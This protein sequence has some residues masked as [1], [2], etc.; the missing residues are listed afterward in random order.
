MARGRQREKKSTSTTSS[1]ASPSGPVSARMHQAWRMFE[2][3]D[4]LGARREAKDI[5][6]G[7]AS[8]EETRQANDL[9]ERTAI[10]KI[11]F[12]TAAVAAVTIAVLILIAVVRT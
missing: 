10:P 3:G 5:L 1:H 12:I 8:E 6:A 4:K 11:A 9:L 7:T 2:E